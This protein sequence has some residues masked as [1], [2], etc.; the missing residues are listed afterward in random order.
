NLNGYL[1]SCYPTLVNGWIFDRDA[2]ERRITLNVAVGD[3]ML[4]SVVADVFRRDLKESG[5]GDGASAFTFRFP[6]SLTMRELRQLNLRVDGADFQF[7][8]GVRW[9][10]QC[11][12]V[13]AEPQL[14]A[15]MV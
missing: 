15:G 14:P 10:L 3:D 4:G 8:P 9:L 1:D 12:P 5:K 2:P 6:R 7:V 11:P 13:M